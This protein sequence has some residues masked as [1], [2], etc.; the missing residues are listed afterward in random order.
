M[1]DKVKK[2]VSTYVWTLPGEKLN[3]NQVY[4][5][6]QGP[7]TSK[8]LVYD[9]NEA[10][11]FIPFAKEK[12]NDLGESFEERSKSISSFVVLPPECRT[13]LFN[14]ESYYVGPVLDSLSHEMLR[15]Q[16]QRDLTRHLATKLGVKMGSKNAL[17]VDQSNKLFAERGFLPPNVPD[18]TLGGLFDLLGTDLL[19]LPRIMVVLVGTDRAKEAIENGAAIDSSMQVK[20][21]KTTFRDAVYC[22]EYLA[23]DRKS[24]N[25]SNVPPTPLWRTSLDFSF[26]PKKEGAFS[27][28]YSDEITRRFAKHFPVKTLNISK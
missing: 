26:L 17:S 23:F 2:V 12:R 8:P 28:Y 24:V 1:E 11:Y 5:Q 18:T 10:K 20:E 21:L 3:Y 16:F 19:I 9:P 15:G 6:I 25:Q 4:S 22:F 27:I 7:N 14:K 13:F